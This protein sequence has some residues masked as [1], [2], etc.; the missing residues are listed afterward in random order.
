MEGFHSS[1]SK[2]QSPPSS[3][4]F[5]KH[6]LCSSRKAGPIITAVWSIIGIL[7]PDLRDFNSWIIPQRGLMTLVG[8]WLAAGGDMPATS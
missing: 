1:S 2:G 8:R 3:A 4:L 5:P 6:L 7:L